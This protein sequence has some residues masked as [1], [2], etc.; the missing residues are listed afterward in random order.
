MSAADE[1]W[2][3]RARQ[4]RARLEALAMSNPSVRMVSI[5]LDPERR[6]QEPVLIVYLSHG[7]A[8]PADLPATI[9]DIPVR[10]A[11]GDYQLEQGGE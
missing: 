10:V 1:R 7:A 4:A 2:W 6:S 8:V 5:G 3:D 9:D 11:Y